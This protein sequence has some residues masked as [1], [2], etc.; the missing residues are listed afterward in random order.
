MWSWKISI[1]LIAAYVSKSQAQLAQRPCGRPPGHIQLLPKHM[2]I[3]MLSLFIVKK[4]GNMWEWIDVIC[5]NYISLNSLNTS[6]NCWRC[7]E[8]FQVD[9]SSS[10][11]WGPSTEIYTVADRPAGG[12]GCPSSEWDQCLG[13]FHL[14]RL[15]WSHRIVTSWKKRPLDEKALVC[16]HLQAFTVGISSESYE[17]YRNLSIWIQLIFTMATLNRSCQSWVSCRNRQLLK[18]PVSVNKRFWNVGLFA[19]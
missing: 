12:R 13:F 9:H 1:E 3:P 5:C 8:I 19:M 7:E 18:T 10:I 14:G 2:G 17:W 16:I 15:V 6:L 11:G 4:C